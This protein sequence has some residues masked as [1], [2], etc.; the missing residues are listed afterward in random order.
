MNEIEREARR[1]CAVAGVDP[2]QTVMVAAARRA[3]EGMYAI[4]LAKAAR[5]RPQWH[6]YIGQATTSLARKA[7]NAPDQKEKRD[8]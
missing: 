5:C 8:E 7:A 6:D 2:D 1:L 3:Q 4:R